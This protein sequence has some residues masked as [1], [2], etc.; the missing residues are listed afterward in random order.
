MGLVL[1]LP[2]TCRRLVG[3]GSVHATG[4]NTTVLAFACR[5]G[6]KEVAAGEPEPKQH[7]QVPRPLKMFAVL[8][9][10]GCLPV[11]VVGSVVYTVFGCLSASQSG[12]YIELYGLD[13]LETGPFTLFLGLVPSLPHVPLVRTRK[14]RHRAFCRRC[15][16]VGRLLDYDYTVT[17][18]RHGLVSAKRKRMIS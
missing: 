10:G 13:Y 12:Q 16:G 17:A 4:V 9:D 6:K 5:A 7:L 18:K 14:S 11:I 1:F 8:A 2:E 3:D 15:S